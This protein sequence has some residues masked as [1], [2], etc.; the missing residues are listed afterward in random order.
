MRTN[1]KDVMARAASVEEGGDHSSFAYVKDGI[2]HSGPKYDN[3]NLAARTGDFVRQNK[4]E[5]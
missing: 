2:R 3:S 1:V 4:R 5:S